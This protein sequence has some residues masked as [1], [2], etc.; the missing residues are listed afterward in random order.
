L[1]MLKRQPFTQPES[2]PVA[3]QTAVESRLL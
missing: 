3:P 2:T 1:R